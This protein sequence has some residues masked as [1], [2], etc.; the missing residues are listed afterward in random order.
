MHVFQLFESFIV[1]VKFLVQFK[2]AVVELP[3]F[4]EKVQNPLLC[5]A[6]A[7]SVFCV[8]I[9]LAVSLTVGVVFRI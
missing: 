7:T 4:F 9:I 6:G 3:F 5:A 1:E 2:S 8:L